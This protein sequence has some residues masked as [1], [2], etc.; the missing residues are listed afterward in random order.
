MKRIICAIFAAAVLLSSCTKIYR[1]TDKTFFAMNTVVNTVVSAEIGEDFTEKVIADIE[2]RM[3][4]TLPDSEI[5]RLNRGEDAVLSDGTIEVLE[6]ALRI[7]GDT[8][9]AFNPCMGTLTDTWDITSGKNVV[10]SDEEI[11]QALSL[12]DA[13]LVEISDGRVKIPDGMKIDLGGVAKGYALQKA[14]ENLEKTAAAEGVGA[15]FCISLGGNVAV[16]GTSK[17]RK[18]NAQTGWKVGITNPFDKS[19]V[20]T[21][22]NLEKGYVSVSGG[23]ER[24]F[25][26][27]GRIYHHIF[28]SR[29]G[30]PAESG[31]ACAVVV[32]DNGLEADALST[33]L[34]VMGREKAVEFYKKGIYDFEM[35][36]VTNEKEIIAG[37]YIYEKMDVTEAENAG[38]SVVEIVK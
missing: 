19:L 36:L 15:D 17:N 12:C 3:S 11:K 1:Y 27:D 22:L 33:A 20:M 28:D 6:K 14:A 29:T 26:K 37:S 24:F 9:Y 4:R 2:Q 18:E 38:F 31:L 30:Y 25:E 34:F 5:S 35:L 10:P 13:S 23:Y 7:A 8:D 21:T 16:S 32:S